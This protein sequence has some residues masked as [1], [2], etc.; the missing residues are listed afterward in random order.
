M[1]TRI[2]VVG[3]G[4]IARDQHL[5]AL[6]DDPRFEIVG[7]VD[8]HCSE[9]TDP[10]F[11]T[12]EQLFEVMAVDAVAICTPP[13]P[14]YALAAAALRA[15]KHVLLEKPPCTTVGELADLVRRAKTARRT[16]FAAWHSRFAAGVHAA[17]ERLRGE[18]VV[19]FEIHWLEDVRRWHPGQDW[20]WRAGGMGVFDPGINALSILTEILPGEAFVTAADFLVPRNRNVPISAKLELGVSGG[21]KGTACFD[22]RALGL[23]RTHSS[24]RSSILRRPSCERSSC[25]RRLSFCSSHDE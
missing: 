8:P 20:V 25:S 19:D 13:Q 1:P 16:L 7:A 18:T 6:L 23:E 3:L 10:H 9:T 5:R 21:G 22:W 12:L 24:S 15:G 17:R 14:R 4:K 2:A 11:A